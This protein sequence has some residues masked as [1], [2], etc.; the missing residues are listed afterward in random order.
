[1]DIES[2]IPQPSLQPT[3]EQTTL[4]DSA[5]L[6]RARKVKT[7]YNVVKDKGCHACNFLGTLCDDHTYQKY[8]EVWRQPIHL[9]REVSLEFWDEGVMG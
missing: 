1:M 5:S 2:I 9:P 8:Q 3:I 7:K 6:S 4:P